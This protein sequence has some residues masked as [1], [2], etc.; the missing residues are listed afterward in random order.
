MAFWRDVARPL[1]LTVLFIG[2]SDFARADDCPAPDKADAPTRPSTASLQVENDLFGD[3][4]D[5]YYTNGIQLTFAAGDRFV[6]D[7]YKSLL[8]RIPGINACDKKQYVI[9]L[10]QQMFTPEDTTR[11]DP[12]PLDRPYAGWLFG[13]LG[14]VVEGEN[15][16]LVQNVSLDL[17]IV[18]PASLGGYTQRRFHTL[19]NVGLPRGWGK[20]LHNEPGILLTYQ[21]RYRQPVLDENDPVELD[22]MPSAGVALGNVLTQGSVG[23][24]M[25][26]GHNLSLTYGPAFIR[27]SLPAAALVRRKGEFGW[28]VFAGVEARAVAHNI[29]LDGNTIGDSRSVDKKNFVL[30]WQGGV[31]FILGSARL[32]FTQ[33]L[34]TREFDDQKRASQ[35]G[36]ISLSYIF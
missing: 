31:E 14:A 34:R 28:N 11:S 30:D 19:I 17:G 13:S 21:A 25:R 20:Q 2:T 1:V 6:P 3:G 12:D 27:P 33:I 32:T 9:A 24:A 8:D 10:G 7:W 4:N 29:F 5:Q 35:F 16:R 15:S 23:A 36:S 26:F 18:G 22:F